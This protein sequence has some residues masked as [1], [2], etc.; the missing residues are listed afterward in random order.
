MFS[1]YLIDFGESSFAYLLDHLDV[2]VVDPCA[3]KLGKRD[4]WGDGGDEHILDATTLDKGLV[5]CY[6]LF[7]HLERELVGIGT[8]F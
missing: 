4:V 5:N 7:D 3:S 1:V 6:S 2:V 8:P